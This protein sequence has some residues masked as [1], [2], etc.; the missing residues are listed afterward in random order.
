MKMRLRPLAED[1]GDAVLEIFN[2]YIQSS[3]AA[4]PEHAMGAEF[5]K[6]LW[7]ATTGYPRLT[8]LSETDDVVGFAFLRPF[9]PLPAFKLTAEITIFIKSEYTG[10]G[11]GAQALEQL[12]REARKIGITSIIASVSSENSGSIDFHSR[13][14]FRAAGVLQGIGRKWDQPFDV[15]YLQKML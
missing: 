7:M 6:M 9:H 11:T 2:H 3:F 12:V 5:F 13:N 14:G 4:F 8:M 10:H 1:D 15:I